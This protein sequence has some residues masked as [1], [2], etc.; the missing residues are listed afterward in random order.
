M[1]PGRVP[2]AV[3]LRAVNDTA[4]SRGRGIASQSGLLRVPA[5]QSSPRRII[6]GPPVDHQSGPTSRR[7]KSSAK[8]GPGR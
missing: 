6:Q 5:P 7:S 2:V 8:D 1:S 4:T 3:S